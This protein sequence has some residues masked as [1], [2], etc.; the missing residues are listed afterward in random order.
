MRSQLSAPA[1]ASFRHHTAQGDDLL[2]RE[3]SHRCLN[4]LQLIVS[5]LALQG[6]RATNPAVRQALKDA[7]ERV[8]ILARAR[9]AMHREQHQGLECALRQVC[10]AL[11]P[12]AEPRSILISLVSRRE[13]PALS[14]RQVTAIALVVH[15]LVTNAIKHAFKGQGG[16]ISVTI[17]R[18]GDNGA[19]IIV[20][21]DG[22]SLGQAVTGSNGLG[23]S[24]AKRLMASVG[25][26]F[27]PPRSGSKA[28]ELRVTV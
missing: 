8:A 1:S 17:D 24:L 27:I 23:M 7:M 21:D 25:G 15:E 4:D 2:L 12:Q 5:M 9:S 16:Q 26:L 20:E 11:F 10:E 13:A 6:S 22:V 19:T 3:T 28:F 14:E 18:N